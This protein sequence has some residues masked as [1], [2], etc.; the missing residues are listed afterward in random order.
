MDDTLKNIDQLK[1]KFAQ[2]GVREYDDTF[3]QW[4]TEYKRAFIQADLA[5]HDAIKM[6]IEKVTTDI[7]QMDYLLKTADS[8]K[9][10]DKERDRVIDR[11]K[12]Y[13]DFL[14]FFDVATRT[15]ETIEG[16]VEQNIK[17]NK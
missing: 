17:A 2:A 12:I 5:N 6:L 11:K 7:E 13:Q 4:E 14:S 8:T 10:P 9:L 15:K 1:E 16:E 3:R